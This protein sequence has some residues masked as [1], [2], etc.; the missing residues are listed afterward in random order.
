VEVCPFLG[1]ING[2][3]AAD[4]TFIPE[5][6]RLDVKQAEDILIRCLKKWLDE[7]ELVT[8]TEQAEY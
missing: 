2:I 5:K 1:K 6:Y 8:K 4:L 7:M 3:F